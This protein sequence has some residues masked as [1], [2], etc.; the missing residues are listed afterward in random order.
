M[1]EWVR[2]IQRGDVEKEV[3]ER[4]GRIEKSERETG[5][6]GWDSDKQMQADG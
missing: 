1:R 5:E 3:R 4:R 6:T 2:E